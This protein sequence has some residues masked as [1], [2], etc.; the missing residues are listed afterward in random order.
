MR[1]LSKLYPIKEMTH[2]KHT[3]RSINR[4]NLFIMVLTCISLLLMGCSRVAEHQNTSVEAALRSLVLEGPELHESLHTRKIASIRDLPT[5]VKSPANPHLSSE[6]EFIQ[7]V[8]RG[9]S[10]GRLGGDGIRTAL[11]ARYSTGENELGFYGLETESE[12]VADEREEAIREI[13]AHNGR[14]GRSRVHRKGLVLLVVWHD[15]VS[16]ECWESVNATL[17]EQLNAPLQKAR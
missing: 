2:Y 15:N 16:P 13:W 6:N 10:Q 9:G 1:L 4:F 14:F 17:V 5:G 3:F 8:A 7:A 12:A 11:F